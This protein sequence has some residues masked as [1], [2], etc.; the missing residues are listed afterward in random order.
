MEGERV[1]RARECRDKGEGLRKRGREKMR[2]VISCAYYFLLWA[3]WSIPFHSVPNLDRG[4]MRKSFVWILSAKCIQMARSIVWVTLFLPSIL[5]INY[6]RPFSWTH[7][8]TDSL[9]ERARECVDSRERE[10][11]R[12]IDEVRENYWNSNGWREERRK[13][14]LIWLTRGHPSFPQVFW[15]KR[16]NEQIKMSNTCDWTHFRG[17]SHTKCALSINNTVIA[18]QHYGPYVVFNVHK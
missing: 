2:M 7:K 9:F 8:R 3:D 14:W 6:S 12:R 5:P 16:A 13:G 17:V 15:T 11:E 10:R 18:E 1:S 4:E